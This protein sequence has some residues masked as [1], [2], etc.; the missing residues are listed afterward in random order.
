MTSGFSNNFF[1]CSQGH[2]SGIV[3]PPFF[4]FP[5][6]AVSSFAAALWRVKRRGTVRRLEVVLF[7]EVLEDVGKGAMLAE[8]LQSR[9]RSNTLDGLEV[10]ASEENAK[11][12]ELCK[13]PLRVRLGRST[14]RPRRTCD[15]FISSPSRTLSKL[16]SAIGAFRASE[17]VRWR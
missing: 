15:M 6:S 12:Y 8:K 17:N 2:S 14:R 5:S 7:L 3:M 10:I 11:I 9:L 4:F 16:I 13:V 1:A